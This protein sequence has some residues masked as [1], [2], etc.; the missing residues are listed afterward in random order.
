M[1]RNGR[2]W[3]V[4]VPPDA[5]PCQAERATQVPVPYNQVLLVA[6]AYRAPAGADAAH[7]RTSAHD[8]RRY[9][10]LLA[11]DGNTLVCFTPRF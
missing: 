7:C 4:S 3:N 6:A 2:D 10:S 8:N 1:Y 5:V 9:W 11:D